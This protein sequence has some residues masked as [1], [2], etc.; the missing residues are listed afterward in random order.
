MVTDILVC[1]HLDQANK[2]PIVR[3]S[4]NRGLA[5][6]L[7]VNMSRGNGAHV[8][9]K[10][11]ETEMLRKPSEISTEGLHTAIERHET[12]MRKV[13]VHRV[14]MQTRYWKL[15]YELNKRAGEET[16]SAE[17]PVE[18]VEE[19][20]ERRETSRSPSVAA[21]DAP[22][23]RPRRRNDSWSIGNQRVK[24]TGN[25]VT[26]RRSAPEHGNRSKVD[27][28]RSRTPRSSER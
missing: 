17:P 20:R 19:T 14:R 15:V 22:A 9:L 6:S 28:R 23:P 13:E 16:D 12:E 27:K 24:L 1:C 4:G 10:T 3:V 2:M 25:A 26:R 11:L 8:K 5:P 21:N 7:A 18:K